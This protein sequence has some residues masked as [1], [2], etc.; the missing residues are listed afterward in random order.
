[1]AP[2]VLRPH[3]PPRDLRDAFIAI[4]AHFLIAAAVLLIGYAPLRLLLD[5]VGAS[6]GALLLAALVVAGVGLH[7][8]SALELDDT[9]I[10]F[11]RIAGRPRFLA[12]DNVTAV[13]RAE[14]AEVVL[15]GWLLPPIPPRAAARS[16]T[17]V[18]HYRFDW[19]GGSCYFPP[20]DE[21][22]LLAH[23][24]RNWGGVPSL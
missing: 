24:E 22:A 18:G 15:H 11:R 5:P 10:R 17:S 23:L 13:S 9:G 1:M 12:W 21:V 16:V 2:L 20:E 8:V 7:S 3:A 14:R 4:V 6:I 19:A